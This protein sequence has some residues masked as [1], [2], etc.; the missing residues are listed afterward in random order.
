VGGGLPVH[1]NRR[2]YGVGAFKAVMSILALALA[3]MM[4]WAIGVSIAGIYA[5]L[6]A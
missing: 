6:Q 3:Y 1:A 2:V 5:L 4:F